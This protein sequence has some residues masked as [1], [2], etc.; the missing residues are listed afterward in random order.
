[1]ILFFIFFLGSSIASF[2]LC[3]NERRNAGEDFIF[4]RSKCDHCKK[5]IP[6]YLEIP[7][8]SYVFLMGKCRYCKEKISF[9]Y[10]FIELIGGLSLIF[11]FKNQ[12]KDL[13]LLA[14]KG[15]L[16]FICLSIFLSDFFYKD[17]YDFDVF[18][19]YIFLAILNFYKGNFKEFILPYIFLLLVFYLIFIITKSMGSG[20]ILLGASLG[21]VSSNIFEAFRYFTYTFSLGALVGIILILLKKKGRKDEIAFGPF[22]LVVLFGVIFCKY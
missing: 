1:M 6:M 2:V 20:D 22:I 15:L 7:L 12:S 21:L 4:S 17:I 18:I 11:I 19:L 3:L 13:I 10:P 5:I 14:I 16:F 9:I 8:I